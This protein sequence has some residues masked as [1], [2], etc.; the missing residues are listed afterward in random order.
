MSRSGTS[1]NDERKGRSQANSGVSDTELLLKKQQQASGDRKRKAN[2]SPRAIEDG[3]K[4]PTPKRGKSKGSVD[5]WPEEVITKLQ[6]W[7]GRRIN[8][9]R[10]HDRKGAGQ[11][12][13][14]VYIPEA[15]VNY[16]V[17]NNLHKA[18]KYRTF[19]D[20]V[21]SYIKSGAMMTRIPLSSSKEK[22]LSEEQK[23]EVIKSLE[24]DWP[25]CYLEES[26]QVDVTMTNNLFRSEK[27]TET[28]NHGSCLKQANTTTGKDNSSQCVD[29]Q[30]SH[31]ITT[32]ISEEHII[33][34]NITSGDIVTASTISNPFIHK[35]I[36]DNDMILVSE[37]VIATTGP[38]LMTKM[39]SGSAHFALGQNLHSELGQSLQDTNNLVNIVDNEY[40]VIH[41][42]TSFDIDADV[43]V[44][45]IDQDIDNNVSDDV[46]NK[47]I[48][49]D[50]VGLGSVM[51]SLLDSTQFTLMPN[52][53]SK[54][55]PILETDQS[56]GLAHFTSDQKFIAVSH[57]GEKCINGVNSSNISQVSGENNEGEKIPS[58]D[59]TECM[60][61]TDLPSNMIFHE[62]NQSTINNDMANINSQNQTSDSL[63]DIDHPDHLSYQINSNPRQR[64]KDKSKKHPLESS[65]T[66]D[67][68]T[69]LRKLEERK[70]LAL[71]PPDATRIPRKTNP[72]SQ[73]F[74][75][76]TSV[77]QRLEYYLGL[78]LLPRCKR[79]E[80]NKWIPVQEIDLV[81]REFLT[82]IISKLNANELTQQEYASIQKQWV[83]IANAM[84]LTAGSYDRS[85]M[86]EDG[87]ICGRPLITT[88]RKKK[89]RLLKKL[90]SAWSSRKYKEV[91]PDNKSQGKGLSKSR[92]KA[93][94]HAR[95]LAQNISDCH[96][97]GH[98]A[99]LE[100]E[101]VFQNDD[102]YLER[103]TKVTS[104][105]HLSFVDDVKMFASTKE[106][107]KRMKKLFIEV[108]KEM[109]LQLNLS[110][111]GVIPSIQEGVSLIDD[112]VQLD[113]AYKY[114]GMPEIGRG[115]DLDNLRVTLSNK[116]I[117]KTAS[118]FQSCLST[119]Q[120]VKLYNISIVP[121]VQYIV[122]HSVASVSMRKMIALCKY[123]DKC[124]YKVLS[125][126]IRDNE[127]INLRQPTQAIARL[128]LKP[129]NGGLG[130]MSLAESAKQAIITYGLNLII[131]PIHKKSKYYFIK[132]SVSKR[133]SP[134]SAFH[135]QMKE[136]G[137]TYAIGINGIM[138]NEAS[139][140]SVKEAKKA[141]LQL[142]EN[143]HQT[144]L[145]DK[146]TRHM[147]YAKLYK[148]EKLKTPWLAN[149]P[150]RDKDFNLIASAQ[151][152]SLPCF[153]RF[154]NSRA[155]KSVACP[156]CGE[157][158]T[159]SHLIGGCKSKTA[160]N[161]FRQR[162][163]QVVRLVANYFIKQAG[164]KHLTLNELKELDENQDIGSGWCISVDRPQLVEVHGNNA[165]IMYENTEDRD[166]SIQFVHN[167]PDV[168]AVNRELKEVLVIEI[169]VSNPHLLD[170][171]RKIKT[172]RYTVNGTVEIG[173]DNYNLV[174]EDINIV[175]HLRSKYGPQ[176]KVRFIPII[177]GAYGE[178][179]NSLKDDLKPLNIILRN[180]RNCEKFV[181]AVS[182]MVARETAKILKA[183]LGK[184]LD[185]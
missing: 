23:M 136:A 79:W 178:V 19:T 10:R 7:L 48:D 34:D 15:E 62:T 111:C 116:V 90:T 98:S 31:T 153:S 150:M 101:P 37:P 69:Q 110:K 106:D 102:P 113:T 70:R 16:F 27:I 30:H 120:K 147:D 176:Y 103:R 26:F 123:L 72:K 85:K 134:I 12:I 2:E 18:M 22:K 36:V 95:V 96:T 166:R 162:H 9:L 84:M 180:D 152:E 44:E 140:T 65:L 88:S 126:S 68:K 131:D 169:A 59:M 71:E 77:R 32:N 124:V 121:A 78:K 185:A 20:Q 14:W 64:P 118:I 160:E 60:T 129:E 99:L 43:N 168:I 128:L 94:R 161:L 149:A 92:V 170:V 146:W 175:R 83:K 164:R 122:M 56:L 109:G 141:I 112:V 127:V 172:V 156:M 100:N 74:D 171:Q 66:S 47:D 28:S 159:S 76:N 119:G 181:M 125:G 11:V 130:M 6:Q 8:R 29:T 86:D 151:Q 145:F 49:V 42:S 25:R 155:N 45:T 39:S 182:S 183:C 97:Q 82:P 50:K 33:S 41:E 142:M 5:R 87:F 174:S 157:N 4:P 91:D 104:V 81:G 63:S 132:E 21:S 52:L 46:I 67:Q 61:L 173:P 80:V 105:N 55:G 144:D 24:N 40:T 138:V 1:I 135:T 148:Q 3:I 115:I 137:I 17:A 139:F 114:L 117:S 35:Q 133:M 51:T 13:S 163:D 75:Q 57:R 158:P 93:L 54:P 53:H 108:G 154:I 89:E 165:G 107:L 179:K 38:A 177:I 58:L 143:K 184:T 167:R 73:V